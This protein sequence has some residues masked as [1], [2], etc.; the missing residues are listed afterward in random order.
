MAGESNIGDIVIDVTGDGNTFGNIGH[1]IIRAI[2][3]ELRVSQEQRRANENSTITEFTISVVAE[4]TPGCL[5][6]QFLAD[7]LTKVSIMPPP[8]GGVSSLMQR[9]VR[10]SACE[11][12]TEIP[13]PRG[14]YNVAVETAAAT[15]VELKYGF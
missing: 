10:Q 8:V 3:P 12:Y 9:N 13:A 6:L 1:T 7:G 5:Y 2:R 11:Y 4:I 15:P 14:D